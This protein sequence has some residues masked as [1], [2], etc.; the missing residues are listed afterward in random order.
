MTTYQEDSQALIEKLT[1]VTDKLVQAGK[2]V[3]GLAAE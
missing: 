1:Q 3:D 2:A